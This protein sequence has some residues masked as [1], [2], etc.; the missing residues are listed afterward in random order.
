MKSV[1]VAFAIFA[2]GVFAAEEGFKI[3]ITNKVEPDCTRKTE[4]GDKIKV[5]Y[6]GTLESTGDKFDASYD[7]NVPFGFKLGGGQVIKGWE[8]GLLDMCVGEKRTLTVPP[9]MGYGSRQVGPI[10]ASSTLIFET[11]LIGIDGV[12]DEL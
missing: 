7:R 4:K 12:K 8:E 11:E 10:P 5:H 6:R 2:A 9:S 1:I 3:D